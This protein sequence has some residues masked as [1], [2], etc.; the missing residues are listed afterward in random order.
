MLIK[1][2]VIQNVRSFL[3]REEL[4]VDDDITIIIGPNGGGKTNLLDT[5]VIMLQRHLFS[6]MYAVH[7]PTPDNQ[8]RYEFRH[9]DALNNMILDKHTDGL[10]LD[11]MVEIGV[12]VTEKDISNMKTIK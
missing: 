11:Q 9:N 8:D 2:I 10:Q 7:A 5:I 6:S 1:K 12:Q 4:F 3:D